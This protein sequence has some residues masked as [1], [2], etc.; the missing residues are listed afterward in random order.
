MNISGFLSSQASA[1]TG[2]QNPLPAAYSRSN[3]AAAPSPSSDPSAVVNLSGSTGSNTSA[4]YGAPS[5]QG[6]GRVTF[7]NMGFGDT[8]SFGSASGPSRL[9]YNAYRPDG[10]NIDGTQTPPVIRSTG[11]SLTASVAAKYDAMLEDVAKQR[12]SLYK[13]GLAAGQSMEDIRAS[14]QA[15]DAGLPD[16]YKALVGSSS[17][18]D[19]SQRYMQPTHDEV[20]GGPPQQI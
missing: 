7:D 18:V 6:G 10:L 20:M 19:P 1:S 15:F 13:S 16:S 14:L 5:S 17:L 9:E 2:T 11:E 3:P 8:P 12:V 4:T